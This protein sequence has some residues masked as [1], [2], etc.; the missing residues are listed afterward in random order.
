MAPF[1]ESTE[2]YFHAPAARETVEEL[3]A[4][5]ERIDAVACLLAWDAET[6]TGRPPLTNDE[7]AAIA[8][9]YPGRFIPVAS[10]DPHKGE[11]A[12]LELERAVKELGMR[13]LKLHP[14][15][16]AF[17]PD[18][19]AFYPLWATA[20]ALGVP[21]ICHT[22]TSGIGAGAPGGQGI[23]LDYARPIHLDGVLADFPALQIVLAHFGWPWT[24]EAIAIALHKRN[25]LLDTSGWAPRYLPP[26]LVREM[27]GRL[28]EKVLF[29]SDFPFIAPER[30]LNELAELGLRDDILPLILHG[31]AE[32][33]FGA[34]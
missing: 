33:T 5:Y 22:G 9:A 31:N 14:Q 13:G 32:R 19:R 18:D 8:A 4:H 26:Q 29:G 11:R 27:S 15:L 23:K 28:R 10:V 30:C 21:V 12:V 3:A 6:A 20:E 25:A 16:Q 7:V 34:H 1:M 24:D 2:A 17:R